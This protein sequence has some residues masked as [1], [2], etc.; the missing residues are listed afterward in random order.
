VQNPSNPRQDI[1]RFLAMGGGSFGALLDMLDGAQ[2][3]EALPMETASQPPGSPAWLPRG[4]RL[5]YG[6][7]AL[8]L[9][10]ADGALVAVFSAQGATGE[11][12][13]RATEEDRR[14]WPTY[15]GP[16]EYA[17]AVRR[18]VE[19]R[20][21]HPWDR[22][23]RTERRMLKARRNGQMAR[24]LLRRLPGEPQ[25]V[26][27]RMVSG[28]RRRAEEG[29]VELRSAEGEFSCKRIEELSPEDRMD[30]IRAE[31]ARIEWLLER[32]ER[33]NAT[34]RSDP[35]EQRQSRKSVG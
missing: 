25:E 1:E 8:I 4:Y 17:H 7:D 34:L 31:L 11:A 29:L 15:S 27:D 28:D 33:H 3:P 5:E 10:R 30:R 22:F 26:L 20:T 16:E 19:T 14:G 21:R 6:S 35:F 24:A 2:A 13:V 18:L 12:V 23:L 9:R 32:R